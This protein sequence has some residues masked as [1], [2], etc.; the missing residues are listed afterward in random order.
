MVFFGHVLSFK[1]VLFARVCLEMRSVVRSVEMTSTG[2]P[3]A[4]FNLSNKAFVVGFIIFIS[5]PTALRVLDTDSFLK[6]FLLH[7]SHHLL[8]KFLKM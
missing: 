3:A 4:V 5:G 1:A 2:S 8:L 6:S 7:S